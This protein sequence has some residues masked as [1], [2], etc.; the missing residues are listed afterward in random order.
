MALVFER[1]ARC[2]RNGWRR[3]SSSGIVGTLYRLSNEPDSAVGGKGHTDKDAEDRRRQNNKHCG[4]APQ[5]KRSLKPVTG[6]RL[7]IAG[8]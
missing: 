5:F 7:S 8:V 6:V 4:V 1:C 3:W 2:G